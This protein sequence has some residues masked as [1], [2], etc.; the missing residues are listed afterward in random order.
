MASLN[1]CHAN[2]KPTT[3]LSPRS[4]YPHTFSNLNNPLAH[5]FHPKRQTPHDSNNGK[6]K[7]RLTRAQ[8]IGLATGLSI[9]AAI[10]ATGLFF[11]I[12][13]RFPVAQERFC[14]CFCALCCPWLMRRT[15]DYEWEWD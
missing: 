3:P 2:I 9:F 15:R 1:L 6:S 4:H 12:L 5:P 11:W 13:S 10:L 8:L 7:P 14:A